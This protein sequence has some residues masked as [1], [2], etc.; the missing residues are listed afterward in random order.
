[1]GWFFGRNREQGS[2]EHSL[3]MLRV[4][5]AIID[6]EPDWGAE[7]IY[8]RGLQSAVVGDFRTAVIYLYKAA[9]AGN[10]AAQHYLGWC[11]EVGRGVEKCMT[12]AVKWY[13]AAAEQG[14]AYAQCCLAICYHKGRGVEKDYDLAAKW[15]RAAAEQGVARAQYELAGLYT[16]GRGVEVSVD[17]AVKWYIAAA[18]KGHKMSRSLLDSFKVKY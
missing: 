8:Q 10:A 4:G 3:E 2:A 13:Q 14:M 12:E 9:T 18:R 16:E 11:F 1:M 5:L 17:E 6:L 15:Y 7:E